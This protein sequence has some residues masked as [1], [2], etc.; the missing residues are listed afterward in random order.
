[1]DIEDREKT[2]VTKPADIRSNRDDTFTGHLEQNP[3]LGKTIPDSNAGGGHRGARMR[4]GNDEVKPDLM[5]EDA[6]WKE[7]KTTQ[8]D[9]DS[10]KELTYESACRPERQLLNACYSDHK[11]N[12]GMCNEL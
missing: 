6:K 1:M 12:K 2:V 11:D 10:D 7:E 8:R 5:N 4:Y 3:N 9:W